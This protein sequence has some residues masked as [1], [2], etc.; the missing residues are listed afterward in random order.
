M[1]GG[2][3]T[4]GGEAGGSG[5]DNITAELGNGSLGLNLS[6]RGGLGQGTNTLEVSDVLD[7]E[8]RVGEV[9]GLARDVVGAGSGAGGGLAA[10]GPS[11]RAAKVE[12][13]GKSLVNEVVVDLAVLVLKPD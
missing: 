6:E 11:T 12:A 3:G 8:V 7:L 9:G 2:G 13:E 5:V 1:A 4:A 10:V